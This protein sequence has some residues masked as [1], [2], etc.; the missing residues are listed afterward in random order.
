MTRSSA[1]WIILKH[2]RHAG[3]D[4]HLTNRYAEYVNCVVL[5]RLA[6]VYAEFF[7][8]QKLPTAGWWFF[9]L[10]F[11]FI[12][13]IKYVGSSLNDVYSGRYVNYISTLIKFV[14]IIFS[15]LNYH[16]YTPLN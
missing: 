6:P 10:T 16:P 15:V 14:S 11:M 2:A 5:N 12:N 8:A 9:S 7:A 1:H 3:V 13:I 4:A